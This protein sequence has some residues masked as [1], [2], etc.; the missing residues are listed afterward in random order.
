MTSLLPFDK[1]VL[2][3]DGNNKTQLARLSGKKV[4]MTTTKIQMKKA[5]LEVIEELYSSLENTEKNITHSY[6]VVGKEDEQATDWRTGELKWEDE[7][8]TIPYYKNKYDY[9]KRDEADFNDYERAKLDAINE[10]RKA[11]DKLI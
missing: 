5:M 11:L 3:K 10:I 9:V 1:I 7:E 8:K 6:E 2:S 4:I